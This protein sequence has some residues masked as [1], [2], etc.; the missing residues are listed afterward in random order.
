MPR[1]VP[2][3]LDFKFDNC[4]VCHVSDQ[5]TAT[6]SHASFTNGSCTITGCHG[7]L[8]Y[9]TPNT[10]PIARPI[11]H[12][13]TDPLDDCVACHLPGET[14]KIIPH[15]IYQDNTMCL[16]PACH[17]VK[18][19]TPT[20]TPPVTTTP[21]TTTIQ[22]T[23]TTSKTGTGTGAGTG[24][25]G[26]TKTTSPTET[27]APGTTTTTTPTTTA[28]GGPPVLTKAALALEVA[29]HPAAYKDL[30]MMC[31]AA[32]MGVQAYPLPPT[33][34]GTPKTPGGPYTI[35][36][37]SDADHTGRTTTADCVKAG[38]HAAPW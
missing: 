16:T 20:T 7:A 2:H 9:T 36:P 5:L 6:V 11:P 35:T 14:G 30:C 3:T 25:G 19:T 22:P 38:C 37:G 1:T 29:T 28:G 15:N 4:N 13:V 33:W 17:V 23:P 21:P 12:I 8:V 34:P 32:G 26:G 18:G 10:S 31:H 27:T 24:T